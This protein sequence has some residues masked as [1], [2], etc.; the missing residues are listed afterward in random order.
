MIPCA[1]GCGT[2]IA[3]KTYHGVVRFFAHGH[4]R[5]GQAG[6]GR[7]RRPLEDIFWE[8]VR[9]TTECWLWVGAVYPNGYGYL[10]GHRRY[11]AHRFSWMLHRGVIP[12]RLFVCHN[13]PG[14]DNPLCV[15]P[16]HLWLGTPK[17]NSEDMVAKGRSASGDKVWAHRNTEQA[18]RNLAYARQF[19][20]KPP[21][22]PLLL[23]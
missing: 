4:N 19:R 3:S 7:P 23:V 9:K 12:K 20:H 17:Q 15:N 13:C 8:N 22:Q 16:A 1:C 11:S 10:N 5:R 21:I 18:R 6:N 2:L 14:G